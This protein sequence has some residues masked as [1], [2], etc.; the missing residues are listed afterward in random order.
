M[1]DVEVDLLLP[2]RNGIRPGPR[3]ICG[4]AHN[5]KACVSTI[6]FA[7]ILIGKAK[8]SVEV[9]T[10]TDMHVAHI[11]TLHDGDFLMIELIPCL[12][13]AENE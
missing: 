11:M 8:A 4:E 5:S 10:E 13:C 2:S 3:E 9:N 1:E 6:A 12:E 7:F